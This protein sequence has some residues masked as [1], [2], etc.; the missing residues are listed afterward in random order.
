MEFTETLQTND[1]GLLLIGALDRYIG[2][3]EKFAAS[4][5][6]CRCPGKSQHTLLEL[7]R[8]RAYGLLG[9]YA[10][11]NDAARLRNDPAFRVLLGKSLDGQDALATQSTLSRFENSFNAHS[12]LRASHALCDFVIARQ[13]KKHKH[14]R[15]ITIDINP[16]DDPTHGQQLFTFFNAYY[17]CWCYLPLLATLTFHDR[18][19]REHPEQHLVAAMLR[20][21]NAKAYLGATYLIRRLVRKLRKAFPGAAL[22]FRMDGVFLGRTS[23]TSFLANQFRVLLSAAAYILAQE[24]RSLCSATA[25]ARWQVNTLRERLFKFGAVVTAS[26]RRWVLRLARFAPDAALLSTLGRRLAAWPPT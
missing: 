23:C 2:L 8:Q 11:G 13:R 4:L 10:D 20:P 15:R 9:G 18:H 6:D 22:R 5:L 26:T 25:A 12:L 1:A 7:L 16:T 3:T 14:T 17:D 21:G 19:G 24:F